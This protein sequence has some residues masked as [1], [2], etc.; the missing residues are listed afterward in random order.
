MSKESRIFDFEDGLIRFG[1]R[2]IHVAERLPKTRAANHK[3]GEIIRRAEKLRSSKFLI[4]YSRF[5][6][7][8][9]LTGQQPV[10]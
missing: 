3:A 10:R 5:M 4:R 1:L 8:L 7:K 6:D 9:A 2:I